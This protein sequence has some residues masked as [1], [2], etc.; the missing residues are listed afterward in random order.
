M[1]V[2][3]LLWSICMNRLLVAAALMSAGTAAYAQSRDDNKRAR[4]AMDMFGCTNQET[5]RKVT[6]LVVQRDQMAAAMQDLGRLMAARECTMLK[7]DDIVAVEDTTKVAIEGTTMQAEVT[8]VRPP[9]ET[10]CFWTMTEVV[11]REQSRPRRRR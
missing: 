8:C 3:L 4:I 10:G 9:G 11:S 1:P 5:F 7:K 6:D 2:F